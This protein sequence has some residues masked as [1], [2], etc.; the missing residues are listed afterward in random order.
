MT[1]IRSLPRW[2][3]MSI[4]FSA[5]MELGDF[6]MIRKMLHGL[7]ERAEGRVAANGRCLEQGGICQPAGGRV[8]GR[9]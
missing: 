7:Q 2:T 1:R 9:I 5:L 4:A 6:R 8:H 3:P